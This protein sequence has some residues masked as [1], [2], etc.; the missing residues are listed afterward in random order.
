MN[1]CQG[2]NAYLSSSIQTSRGHQIQSASVGSVVRG[3]L[4]NVR[5]TAGRSC[6]SVPSTTVLHFPTTDPQRFTSGRSRPQKAMTSA[7]G[8]APLGPFLVVRFLRP[9]RA[10]FSALAKPISVIKWL[11][12]QHFSKIIVTSWSQILYKFRTFASFLC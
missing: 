2:E 11:I 5:R 3:R 6:K 7:Y 10:P 4:S 1:I 9:F 12:L 8:L